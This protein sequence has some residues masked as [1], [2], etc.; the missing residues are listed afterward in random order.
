MRSHSVR[1]TLLGPLGPVA[2]EIEWATRFRARRRGVI[3]RR[4]LAPNEALVIWPCRQV[5][6]KGVGYPLDAVFCDGKLRIVHIE[7]LQPGSRSRHVMRARCC[8]E[9]RGGRA[10]ECGLAPGVRLSLEDR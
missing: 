4:P 3:G 10:K 7:T 5:H 8:V 2:D 9:L 1:T 6:T